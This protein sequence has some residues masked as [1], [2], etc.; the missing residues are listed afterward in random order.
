[1][2]ESSDEQ[3]EA[4]REGPRLQ[5][6]TYFTKEALG[7]VERERGSAYRR[8]YASEETHRAAGTHFLSTE[9]HDPQR[10]TERL[11][12]PRGARY[13]VYLCHSL[14]CLILTPLSASCPAQAPPPKKR[15]RGISYCANR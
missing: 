13:E 4:A 6:T 9:T 11:Q 5:V 3:S 14:L 12:G 2:N 10:H 15:N 1:M 8:G 7:D